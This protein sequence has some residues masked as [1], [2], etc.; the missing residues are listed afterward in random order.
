MS[1]QRVTLSV[2]NGVAL[3]TLNRPDKHNAIDMAM[4]E[5]IDKTIKQ[6]NANREI[7]VVIV[8]GAGVSFCSGLDVKSVLSNKSGALRL[9]W[10]WL[11]GNANLAQRVS[12]GWRRLKV[13][14][15][16][17]LHGKCW[18]GGMQ[19]ALGG[20]FRIAATDCSLS[21]ME[22]QWGL[23]PDMGGTPALRECVAG[24]QGMKLAMT[25]EV[26]DAEQALAVGLITQVSDDPLQAAQLLAQ[27]LIERSP[28]TNRVIKKM[29]HK[30]WSV[31]ERKILALETLNQIKIIAGKNQSIAVKRKQGRTDIDY[32]L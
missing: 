20:D 11:P 30:I 1:E 22:T 27:Q 3:V 14:V 5:G 26:I 2:E 8:T 9:L 31:N 24:D 10:K 19:I 6:I 29:Y 28:D 23:I 7:R 15:I 21:I 17:V 4:F 12:I 25:S 18:G 13:P 16:M 32:K